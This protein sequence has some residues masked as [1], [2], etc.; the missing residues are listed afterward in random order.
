MRDIKKTLTSLLLVVTLI[1]TALSF[2]A[3]SDDKDDDKE[4]GGY[5]ITN[6]YNVSYYDENGTFIETRTFTHGDSLTYPDLGKEG[7]DLEWKCKDEEGNDYTYP[8]TVV[9]NFS[10]YANYTLSDCLV[11][12]IDSVTDE[13][14]YEHYYSY[15]DVYEPSD[16]STDKPG[17]IFLGFSE[18]EK[19][20]ADSF[21]LTQTITIYVMYEA[22]D[23]TL[24]FLDDD[25]SK[26][27]G[28]DV[29]NYG[30]YTLPSAPTKNGYVFDGW[31][32]VIGHE[33]V[34]VGG[35]GDKYTITRDIDFYAVYTV[36][37]SSDKSD[38]KGDNTEAA[39]GDSAQKSEQDN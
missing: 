11:T 31:Y 18:N 6:K 2:V 23:Y 12:V 3:C 30:S 35:A 33:A 4:G 7:Y 36:D 5:T 1:F 22:I 16:I 37:T 39:T 28:T 25:T 17:Y 9:D 8:G 21:K 10:A 15:G 19:D 26:L 24:S 29:V 34:R 14:L 20:Y 27:L 38:E 32:A 13:T